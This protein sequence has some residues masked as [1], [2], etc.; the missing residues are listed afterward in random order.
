[1]TLLLREAGL[2]LGEE[3]LCC[4]LLSLG[5]DLCVPAG[6]SSH[7]LFSLLADEFPLR[8]ARRKLVQNPVL[9]VLAR[10]RGGDLFAPL[11]L[12]GLGFDSI[13]G[14][15]SLFGRGVGR[16]DRHREGAGCWHGK[17]L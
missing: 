14:P 5:L 3:R 12:L 13:P 6:H 2:L 1:M 7:G 9:L 11:G 16:R 15:F 8:L 17:G 10:D 4:H